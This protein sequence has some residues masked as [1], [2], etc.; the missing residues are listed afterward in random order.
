MAH[1]QP[2]PQPRQQL[3]ARELRVKTAPPAQLD[4]CNQPLM[5]I[6]LP[7]AGPAYHAYIDAMQHHR[8][9]RILLQHLPPA[10]R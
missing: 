8:L 9:E 6:R 7:D 5:V 3:E 1:K 10:R 4:A 2:A